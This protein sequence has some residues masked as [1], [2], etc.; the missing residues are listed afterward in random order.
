[1]LTTD[2]IRRVVAMFAPN[3]LDQYDRLIG[4]PWLH[5]EI[6][7]KGRMTCALFVWDGYDPARPC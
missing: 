7:D 3:R 2:E 6:D 4:E 1:M 5:V